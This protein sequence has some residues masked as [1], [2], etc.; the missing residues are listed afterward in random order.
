MTSY[1]EIQVTSNFTFLNGASH[2]HELVETATSLNYHAIAITDHNSLAGVVRAH[3]AAHQ[4]NIKILVG[5]RLNFIDYPSLLCLPTN[6]KAYGRLATL[7]TTGSRRAI[8]GQ[9]KLY[10]SD[11]IKNS[12][13]Q[14]LVAL[15][16]TIIDHSFLEHLKK[17][18]GNSHGNCYLAASYNYDGNDNHKISQLAEFSY[19]SDV[20]LVASNNAY[21]HLPERRR[22]QDILTCIRERCSIKQAGFKLQANA[23]R[24]LKSPD[25]MARLFSSYPEAII[26][27]IEIANRCC[28]SLDELEHCYPKETLTDDTPAFD[29]LA[30]LTIKGAQCRHPSG[31][32][33]KLRKQLN[34]ELSLIK[35]LDY[36]PY[37]LTV[38][39]IVQFAKSHNIYCQGRGSAANSSVCYFLGITAVDPSQID[40]LFER[41]ISSARNEPPDI[42]IDFEH[43]RREEVIQHVYA[44]YG[45]D[46]VG[47]T[48]TVTC[49]RA[50]S[51]IRE[52][53]KALGISSDI[54]N[55]LS[56]TVWGNS[57]RAITT[58]DALESGLNPHDKK[59]NLALKLAEELIGFPRH[60]SQHV[61]GM[62][63]TQDKLSEIVPITN[64]AM[65]NRTVIEWDKDDI[66]ALGILKV[67]ILGLGILTCLHKSIDLIKLHYGKKINLSKIPKDDSKVYKMLCQADT[68]GVFQVESRAQMSM[69]P[70][71]KPQEFYDLVIQVAIVR[72]GPI[73]G[74]MVH[75][76]LRRR[77]GQE[78][79]TYPSEELYQVLGKTLGVPLFQEQAMRIA[80][81]GA[82]FTA[83]EADALRRAMATFRK[84]GL[85]HK[86][87]IKMI[88]G[89]RARGYTDSFAKRCFEQI[90][91]FGEYGF[92]E[93]HA[94]SFALLAY[95]SAWL[96]HH[97]PAVF[98][99]S[100]LNSQPMGFY[101]P[102]QIV[103]DLC[104]AE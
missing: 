68:I 65:E 60:L 96:K 24:Y 2:P 61:G 63:I 84:T 95:I 15:P 12:A 52:V 89:M 90:E 18:S 35:Q 83:A 11:L 79:V 29:R 85:I 88:H 92:P 93:S 73:Q 31:I 72:P 56:K 26:H 1:A 54:V 38:H 40:L 82:G 17:L 16:P 21:Y 49:Y 7:L 100:L 103:K 94:A 22:L 104:H 91:G 44:K 13:D 20:P 19:L 27:T 80:V 10:Y 64:A 43:D 47:M 28:F 81:V 55:I 99:A 48:A 98:G 34:H 14:I 8:K 57:R 70:R 46:R 32:P 42:D 87:R 86:F 9:C 67:D 41:F 74:D 36:A 33:I 6:R 45:R 39:E 77:D 25:E 51:A 71:L 62:V 50:R 69:L 101:A 66:D 58:D 30:Q 97:Y 5:A 37:F 75:P 3:T 4:K 102:A 59:L 53:G 23:E 78:E 76:Y